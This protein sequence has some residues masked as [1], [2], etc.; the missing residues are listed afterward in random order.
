[1]AKLRDGV[2]QYRFDELPVGLQQIG[3]NRNGIVHWF[4]IPD[5]DYVRVYDPPWKQQSG[6]AYSFYEGHGWL[7]GHEIS[8]HQIIDR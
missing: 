5:F 4:K 3:T 1:M 7:T 8:I 6:I 2:S